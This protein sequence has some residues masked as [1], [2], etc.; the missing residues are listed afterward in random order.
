MTKHVYL[1][2]RIDIPDTDDPEDLVCEC[3]YSF[4]HPDVTILSTEI[5]EYRIG[6]NEIGRAHV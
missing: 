1:T 4:T 3:D 6:Y 5:V 2:V